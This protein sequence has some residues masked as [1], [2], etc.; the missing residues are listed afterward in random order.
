MWKIAF[1]RYGIRV[2]RTLVGYLPVADLLLVI[3]FASRR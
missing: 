2:I 3:L 1:D